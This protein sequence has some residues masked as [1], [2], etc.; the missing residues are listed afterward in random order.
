MQIHVG[1][2]VG[3]TTNGVAVTAPGFQPNLILAKGRNTQI[4]WLWMS[5][6]A[7]GAF[8]AGTGATAL[9]TNGP[10]PTATGFTLPAAAGLA[11]NENGTTYDYW[12]VADNG[13]GDFG[14]TSYVGNG[15]VDRAIPVAGIGALVPTMALVA[16]AAGA[17]P[18]LRLQSMEADANDSSS[19]TDGAVTTGLIKTLE[20]GGITVGIDARVNTATATP[21]YHLAAF[22]NTAIFWVFDAIYTGNGTSQTVTPDGS[23]PAMTPTSALVKAATAQAACLKFAGE[24][25]TN[26]AIL[27]ANPEGTTRITAVVANGLSVGASGTVNAASTAYYGAIFLNGTTSG[28]APSSS[29]PS[30]TALLMGIS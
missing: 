29:I 16:S 15:A 30:Q 4:S 27:N 26:C 7:N 12:A 9:G 20:V 28:G 2:Y 17:S 19:N 18:V 5:T 13:A 24:S 22:A 14:V 6:M 25:G 10:T 1:T 8:K 3:D 23:T 11:L 21:T